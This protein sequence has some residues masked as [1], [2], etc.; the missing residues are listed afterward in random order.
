MA[1]AYSRSVLVAISSC[2][3][4]TTI[5]SNLW[6]SLCQLGISRTKPTKRG[7]RAGLR[8]LK[9]SFFLERPALESTVPNVAD[10]IRNFLLDFR[11]FQD[12]QTGQNLHNLSESYLNIQD[13]I[14]A[15]H[16]QPI[17]EYFVP[18]IMLTNVTSLEHTSETTSV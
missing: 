9:T 13:D 18:N 15:N 1:L 5:N 16:Q 14:P 3:T 11:T 2:Q 7:F 17:K 6:R 12:S 10:S 8:K 4:R